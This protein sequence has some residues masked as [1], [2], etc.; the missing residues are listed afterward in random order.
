MSLPPLSAIET[1]RLSLL[2]VA[3]AHLDDLLEVNGDAQVTRFVPYKTWVTRRDG[4]AWLS[5]MTALAD[6]GGAHQLVLKRKPDGKVVGTLL[7]F[8]FNEASRRLEIG[9][10][11]GRACW[12]QGFMREAV[13]A[14][15]DHAFAEMGIRRIEAEVNPSNAAS[16]RL[17]SRIGFAL[18]GTLRQRWT[19]KGLT[20][21][22]HIYGLLVDE[23]RVTSRVA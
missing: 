4:E 16:C 8:K 17:L 2:P 11:L 1:A 21:D 6:S 22:T 19:A 5:R 7:L 13:S 12:G 3:P 23:W 15:C 10:A 9:Y 14:T 20:Y 18:E